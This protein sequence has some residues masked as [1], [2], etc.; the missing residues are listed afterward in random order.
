MKP[1]VVNVGDSLPTRLRAKKSSYMPA[2]NDAAKTAAGETL[3]CGEPDRDMMMM[4]A[5]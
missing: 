3:L 5:R 2:R 4:Q 1:K